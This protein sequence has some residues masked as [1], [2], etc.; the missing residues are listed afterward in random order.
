MDTDMQ[1]DLV[2]LRAYKNKVVNIYLFFDVKD[3][4]KILADFLRDYGQYT[5]KPEEYANAYNWK[6]GDV[7]LSLKYDPNIDKGVA[8][9]THDPLTQEIADRR[10]KKEQIELLTSSVMAYANL[11][12]N[13]K[14]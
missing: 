9:F 3:A 13:N 2:G 12:S 6:A 4:Y 7:T 14:P 1:L 8:I 11:A 5:G 10:K